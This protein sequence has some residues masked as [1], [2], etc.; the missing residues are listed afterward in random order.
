MCSRTSAVETVAKPT[1]SGNQIG[2]LHTNGT[3]SERYSVVP[4][5]MWL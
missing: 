2:L 1:R 5:A 4:V 3:A